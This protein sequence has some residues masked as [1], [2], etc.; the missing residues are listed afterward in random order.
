MNITT[1]ADETHEMFI[2]GVSR[3]VSP[4]VRKVLGWPERL[5][6]THAL[7]WGYSYKRLTLAQLLGC[8]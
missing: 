6:L 4:L 7:L 1:N 3:L 2:N 5:K 8:N